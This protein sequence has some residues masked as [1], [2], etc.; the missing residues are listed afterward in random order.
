[1]FLTWVLP[2]YLPCLLH[3]SHRQDPVSSGRQTGVLFPWP[4]GA[5]RAAYNFQR[6]L[7]V[8]EVGE[9]TSGSQGSRGGGRGG[10]GLRVLRDVAPPQPVREAAARHRND[11]GGGSGARRGGGSARAAP[12][13]AGRWVLAGR[14]GA[15][16]CAWAGPGEELLRRARSAHRQ[17][18]GDP[19]DSRVAASPGI[20]SSALSLGLSWNCFRKVNSTFDLPTPCLSLKSAF[21][22]K[23]PAQASLSAA[24]APHN[25][26]FFFFLPDV[27]VFTGRA[28]LFGSDPTLCCSQLGF[29][30]FSGA[31]N[32]LSL[33]VLCA[34]SRHLLT[35]AR[36]SPSPGVAFACSLEPSAAP[37]PTG[38]RGGFCRLDG[39]GSPRGSVVRSPD[40][41]PPRPEEACT[42]NPW[43]LH[44]PRACWGPSCPKIG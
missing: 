44:E 22:C 6:T 3:E 31:Q 36:A 41:S 39:Q 23:P 29:H 43:L 1:M 4:W 24:A 20:S 5:G 26:F 27:C 38:S 25:F 10:L 11:G 7:K 28:Q 9:E 34:A 12:G 21:L 14:A 42:S 15:G 13:S 16:G 8:L 35:A 19:R 33:A 37:S 40:G 17:A 2:L 32:V 18:L 30:S